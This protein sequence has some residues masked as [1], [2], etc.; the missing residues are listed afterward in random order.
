MNILILIDV[1]HSHWI[2]LRTSWSGD[3]AHSYKD[4]FYSAVKWDYGKD[5]KTTDVPFNHGGFFYFFSFCVVNTTH[6]I[7]YKALRSRKI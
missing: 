3:H 7:G 5:L 1:G 6:L 4:L 2:D